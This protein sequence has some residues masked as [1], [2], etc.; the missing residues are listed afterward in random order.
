M[1]L[2][3]AIDEYRKDGNIQLVFDDAGHKMDPEPVNT[4]LK[5]VKEGYTLC[6]EEEPE[7][8]KN[9]D[10]ANLRKIASKLSQ[11]GKWDDAN[12]LQAAASA[13]VDYEAKYHAARKNLLKVLKGGR[14]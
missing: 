7:P 10:A 12:T 2:Q 4:I 1:N 9:A 14:L 13:L 11:D 8:N 5:A 3:E 6:P